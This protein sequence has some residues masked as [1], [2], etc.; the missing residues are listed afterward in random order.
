MF[1]HAFNRLGSCFIYYTAFNIHHSITFYINTNP[2]Y[3]FRFNFSRVAHMRFHIIPEFCAEII[4]CQNNYVLCVLPVVFEQS[5]IYGPPG[6]EADD[7]KYIVQQ[8]IVKIFNSLRRV[9]SYFLECAELPCFACKLITVFLFLVWLYSF[10]G[11][12]RINQKN[13][14]NLGWLKPERVFKYT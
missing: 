13:D 12:V 9:S 7:R 5:C 10:W 14:L 2:S 6:T 8:R 11:G 4:F 3:G 1:K